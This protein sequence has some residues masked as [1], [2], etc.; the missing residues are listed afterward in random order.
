MLTSEL[1]KVE[2]HDISVAQGKLCFNLIKFKM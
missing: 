1:S 2:K